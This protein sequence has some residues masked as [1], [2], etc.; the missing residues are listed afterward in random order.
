[1]FN[2][3][4]ICLGGLFSRLGQSVVLPYLM[5]IMHLNRGIPVY[6]VGI[7]LSFS[8]FCN[9]FG[10]MILRYFGGKNSFFVLKQWI[11]VYILAFILLYFASIKSNG[12][13]FICLFFIINGILGLCRA[14]IETV[15]QIIISKSSTPNNSKFNFSLRYWCINIGAFL[16]PIIASWLHVLDSVKSFLFMAAALMLY[17][18]LLIL[19]KAKPIQIIYA[20]K[21]FTA[22]FILG[23]QNLKFRYFLI[24]GIIIFF[25]FTQMEVMFA[26]LVNIVTGSS[27][28]FIY[29][30]MINTAMVV[31]LQLPIV[32]FLE[33]FDIHVTIT[34]GTV[35]LALGLAII[36]FANVGLEFYLGEGLFT[37]GEIA[38]IALIG[39]YIDLGFEEHKDVYY[40]LSNLTIIGKIIGAA[41]SGAMIHF[42]G[43]HITLFICALT[44]LGAIYTIIKA[45]NV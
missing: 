33:K 17:V 18:G 2:V 1:M 16:G 45:K 8:Y 30:Y 37:L 22:D 38:T 5:V 10:A 43:A 21:N 20:T 15:G 25:G 36:S 9:A 3:F 4:I 34:I 27:K 41:F 14:V 24:S 13:T 11:V 7:I 19:N 31:C 28:G 39:L 23:W 26:Y 44:T 6:I 35:L 29:M 40:S 32:K 42:A 12:I